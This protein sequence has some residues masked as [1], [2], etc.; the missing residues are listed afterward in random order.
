MPVTS[1]LRGLCDLSGKNYTVNAAIATPLMG[2]GDY[3]CLELIQIPAVFIA[4]VTR[5][6]FLT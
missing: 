2:S 3:A 4:F 1:S 6:G 5:S